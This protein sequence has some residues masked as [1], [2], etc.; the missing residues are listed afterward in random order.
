MCNKSSTYQHVG[1]IFPLQRVPIDL[2]ATASLYLNEKDIFNFEQ[3]CRLFYNV[4]NNTSY[5]SK[6][7]NLKTFSISDKR[8]T[9][10]TCSKSKC[11]F[12]KYS[13]ATELCFRITYDGSADFNDFKT[14]MEK[15]KNSQNYGHWF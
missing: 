4:I 7:N 15:I 11:C 9:Q 8:L 2:I 10:T 3:C 5:L 12:F 6:C 1:V 13:N 14:T